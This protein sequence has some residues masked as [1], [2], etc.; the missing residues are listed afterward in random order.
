[1]VFCYSVLLRR[2]RVGWTVEYRSRRAGGAGARF[3]GHTE[4]SWKSENEAKRSSFG[5]RCSFPQLPV[6]ATGVADHPAQEGATMRT[7]MGIGEAG[8]AEE[9]GTSTMLL[10][11]LNHY[12]AI[13][14]KP[15]KERPTQ[16]SPA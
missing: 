9:A 6:L 4:E 1:M 8:D 16:P 5:W 7:H 14:G 10:P 11:P 2:Q 3:L 15:W 12:S 13:V